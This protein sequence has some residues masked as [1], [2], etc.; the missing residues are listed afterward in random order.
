V[1]FGQISYLRPSMKRAASIFLLSLFL[2]N[3]IGYYFAFSFLN[4]K[5]TSQMSLIVQK[6]NSFETL[7]IH[8]SELKNI[9]FKDGGKEISYKDEM[10]DVKD[11]VIDGDYIVFQCIK[12]S[13]EKNLLADLDKNI[14]NNIDA[15]SS[16]GKK[17][18][19]PTK[20]LLN[21][22]C[23][24]TNRSFLSRPFENAIFKNFDQ[25]MVSFVKSIA[26]PPPDL[27]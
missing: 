14:Q 2:Y 22:Y 23:V 4:W 18:S 13:K 3:V 19:N 25:H 17:K 16:S 8:K 26:S 21:D 15:K 6:S 20:I 24:N 10:Y 27:A 9:V 11:K 1:T 12:D 7:R 5:N